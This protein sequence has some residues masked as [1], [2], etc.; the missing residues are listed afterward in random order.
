MRKSDHRLVSW[1]SICGVFLL[2]AIGVDIAK[3][4]E[5]S[6]RVRELIRYIT[7]FD[8]LCMS[9]CPVLCVH[10]RRLIFVLNR[11]ASHIEMGLI[12]ASYQCTIKCN[13]KRLTKTN[14]RHIFIM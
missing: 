7:V 12:I 2:L 9:D 4:D 8:M 5:Y 1:R 10:C 14:K 11:S 13:R 6:H 3:A